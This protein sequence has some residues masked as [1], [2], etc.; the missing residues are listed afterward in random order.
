MV[1]LSLNVFLQCFSVNLAF[2]CHIPSISY[3]CVAINVFWTG[4]FSS[5][6]SVSCV[7]K[8]GCNLHLSRFIY[9]TNAN[10][11]PCNMNTGKMRIEVV[12]DNFCT[13]SIPCTLQLNMVHISG[14][15]CLIQVILQQITTSQW[16]HL[17]FSTQSQLVHFLVFH[18]GKAAALMC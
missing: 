12:W 14:S 4:W 18:D 9:E 15:G 10:S 5:R 3:V 8:H 16:R 7:W 2:C 11:L 17:D 13:S 1:L 6:F